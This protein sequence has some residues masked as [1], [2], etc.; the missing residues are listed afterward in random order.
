MLDA[1]KPHTAVDPS[2]TMAK[3][4]SRLIMVTTDNYMPGERSSMNE[5]DAI[6]I[7]FHLFHAEGI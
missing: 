6:S 2:E 7:D 3:K 5:N 1:E 4:D